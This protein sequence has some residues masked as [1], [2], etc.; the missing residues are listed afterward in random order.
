LDWESGSPS[1]KLQ[2]SRLLLAIKTALVDDKGVEQA[3]LNE[4]GATV[5]AAFPEETLQ[6]RHFF[7]DATFQIC[8][9]ARHV[10]KAQR[11]MA[12]LQCDSGGGGSF[13]IS[14]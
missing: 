4:S 13:G 3:R 7:V 14:F 12:I 1:G 2:V 5:P 8:N 9:P 10:H 6:S 11:H